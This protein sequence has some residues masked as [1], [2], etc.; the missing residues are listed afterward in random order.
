MIMAASLALGTTACK[1]GCTD[2]TA[3]NYDEKAKKDA[4]KAISLDKNFAD[5]YVN[6]GMAKEMLRDLEGACEDWHKA[7]ELGSELGKSY[8]SANCSN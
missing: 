2:P 4:E 7:K 1:K 8:N 6:R 3:T 5:A